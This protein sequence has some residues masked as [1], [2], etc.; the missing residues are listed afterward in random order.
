MFNFIIFY[1]YFIGFDSTLFQKNSHEKSKKSRLEHNF[2]HL[3][4]T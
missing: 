1:I 4:A 3:E 2:V